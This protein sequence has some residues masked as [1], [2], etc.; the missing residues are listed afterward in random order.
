[1][2]KV[3]VESHEVRIPYVPH[4]LHVSSSI[5]D[6]DDIY[7]CGLLKKADSIFKGMRENKTI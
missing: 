3:E 2:L 5:N 1:M 4:F 7:V 6:D